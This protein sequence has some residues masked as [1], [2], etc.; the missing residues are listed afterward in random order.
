LCCRSFL[1]WPLCCLSFLFWP[2]YCLSFFHWRILITETLLI[3]VPV[4]PLFGFPIFWLW[5]LFQNRVVN[6]WFDDLIFSFGHCVVCSSSIYEFWLPLW[7]IQTLLIVCSIKCLYK[8]LWVPC[9]D[10][11]CDFR[12]KTIL[13]SS[14]PSSCLWDGSCLI[15]ILYVFVCT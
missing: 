3:H 10:V 14:F 13:G 6:S 2:L 4:F 11:R 8:C 12:M 9:C 7:Y 1:F 15:F 5:A